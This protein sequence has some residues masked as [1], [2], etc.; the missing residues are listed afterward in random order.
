[1]KL[2][3]IIP[4]RNMASTV[5]HAIDSAFAAGCDE[6]VVVDDY[7]TD[8]TP[9]VLASYGNRIIVWRWPQKPS[10]WV[11]AQR[12]VWD[13]T[14]ADH[15]TWLGADDWLMPCFG[16]VVRKHA[17][18][19]VVFTD[20]VVVS[21]KSETLW[22]ISQDVEKPTH[23]TPEEMRAR[24]QSPRNATETGSGSSLRSDVARWLWASGF[25]AMGPHADSVGYTTAACLFGC[26]LL[27]FVGAAFT[28]TA[29]SYSR[30]ADKTPDQW[31]AEGLVCK[32]WMESVG[33]DE[34]TT[35]AIAHKRCHLAW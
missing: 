11:A 14:K 20:Y 9:M 17:A 15:Y 3:C 18:A 29:T 30:P 23:L 35:R 27:P 5:G 25:D 34:P 21:P 24:V 7:S 12:V 13:A 19:A 1:M 28:H 22:T 10:D 32:A 8:D 16:D 33:L 2:A 4:V 26:T 31:I 6:V